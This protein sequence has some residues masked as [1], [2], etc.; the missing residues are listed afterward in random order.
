MRVAGV[1][2]RN[3]NFRLYLSCKL[4][5][6]NPLLVAA[7]NCFNPPSLAMAAH[8]KNVM[9]RKR[10]QKRSSQQQIFLDSLITVAWVA[11]LLRLNKLM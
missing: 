11:L 1:Y 3:R 7:E 2:T 9:Q 4:G 10:Q 5:K 8:N 6:N